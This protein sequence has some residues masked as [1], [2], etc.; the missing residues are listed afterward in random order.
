M[1]KCL[2]MIFLKTKPCTLEKK[3]QVRQ[4]VSYFTPATPLWPATYLQRPLSCVHRMAAMYRF[5]C[6]FIKVTLPKV[7]AKRLIL[8]YLVPWSLC[9]DLNCH[10]FVVD[11]NSGQISS[12]K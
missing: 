12:V 11:I 5:N 9:D 3:N 7:T 2:F 8:A 6:L 10:T 4:V 1:W